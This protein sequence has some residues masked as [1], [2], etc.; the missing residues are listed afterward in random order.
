[1]V[2]KCTYVVTA[3]CQSW[4]LH[5]KPPSTYCK[6]IHCE[7]CP[8][9]HHSLTSSPPSISGSVAVVWLIPSGIE[10][11]GNS[12]DGGGKGGNISFWTNASD[13]AAY[14]VLAGW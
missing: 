10:G 5:G 14:E 12:W 11:R 9:C 6:F 3:G 4:C 8:K 2:C 13:W 7:A 1:M